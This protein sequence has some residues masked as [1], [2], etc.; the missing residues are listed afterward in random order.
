M[1]VRADGTADAIDPEGV[2]GIGGMNKSFRLLLAGPAEH[3]A[4]QESMLYVRP[5][6]HPLLL[7][8]RDAAISIGCVKPV[9]SSHGASGLSGSTDFG[10]KCAP[11]CKI[12]GC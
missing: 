4:R 6:A 3:S 8:R 9:E 11:P 10:K 5:T 12:S 1:P 2:E 7:F